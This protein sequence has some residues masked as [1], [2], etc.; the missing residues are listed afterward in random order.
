MA[1]GV[2]GRV[3]GYLGPRWTPGK[4]VALDWGELLGVGVWSELEGRLRDIVGGFEHVVVYQPPQSAR[5][6][7]ALLL[8]GS[9]GAVAFIK[10]RPVDDDGLVRELEVLRHLDGGT[11]RVWIPRVL[12]SGEVGMWRFVVTEPIPSSRH[13]PARSV[14]SETLEWIADS[15]SGVVGQQPIE[16]HVPIHGD[17][18]PWNVRRLT[19]GRYAIFDWENAGWGPRGADSSYFIASSR[20]LG[21]RVGMNPPIPLEAAEFWRERIESRVPGNPSDQ[22]LSAR[23]LAVFADR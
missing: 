17:L 5:R 15:L 4:R 22:I 19:D 21:R 12:A 23:M 3:L 18:T 6:G 13:V 2:A 20:A 8:V 10:A 9:D 1:R 7:L 16:G 11:S 14:D